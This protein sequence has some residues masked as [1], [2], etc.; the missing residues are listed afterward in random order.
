MKTKSYGGLLK[1]DHINKKVEVQRQLNPP[2]Y[3]ALFLNK[4]KNEYP[5]YSIDQLLN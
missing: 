5:D 1:W 3:N 4:L 2:S